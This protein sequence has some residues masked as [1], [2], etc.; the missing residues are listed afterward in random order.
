VTAAVL[1]IGGGSVFGSATAQTRDENWAHCQDAN[2]DLRIGG[3]T[4][5]IQSG[6]ET[7]QSLAGAFTNRGIAY[8]MKGEFDSAIQGFDQAIKLKPDYAEAWNMRCVFRTIIGELQAALT[9]CNESVRLS[10]DEN[11]LASPL[12]YL[13]L[14]NASAV[15]A[16]CDAA[17]AIDPKKAVC[18]YSRALAERM[19]ALC[20]PRAG[21]T[22]DSCCPRTQHKCSENKPS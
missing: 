22:D 14:R 17:L 20:Q 3:C 10:N 2:P 4:A 19:I 18:L 5:L 13:K 6:Q 16:D 12:V 7:T 11:T 1:C 21:P 15:I 9:D 8:A